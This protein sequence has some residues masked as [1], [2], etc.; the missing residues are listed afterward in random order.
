MS[1]FGLNCAAPE[2][3]EE[4]YFPDDREQ[5]LAD[6]TLRLTGIELEVWNTEQKEYETYPVPVGWREELLQALKDDIAHGDLGRR[7]LLEDLER[8]ENCYYTDLR[9]SYEWSEAEKGGT[10]ARITL[11]TTSVETLDTLREAGILDDTHILETQFDRNVY[12]YED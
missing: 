3:V 10:S 1:A 9:I 11:Q 5:A 2:V 4:H 7:Y 12:N 6:G 8:L